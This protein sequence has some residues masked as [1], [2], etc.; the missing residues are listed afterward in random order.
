MNTLTQFY[1]VDR[2]RAGVD[3]YL[4]DWTN[5]GRPIFVVERNDAQILDL[6]TALPHVQ[7]L[8]EMNVTAAL[9]PIAPEAGGQQPATGTQQPATNK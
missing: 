9:M 6:D 2:L 5:E 4:A 3:R 8:L 7:C 1:I